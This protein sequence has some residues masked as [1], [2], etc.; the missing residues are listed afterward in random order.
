VGSDGVRL[1][2]AFPDGVLRHVC[3]ECN[4]L[5][6]R[7]NAI[8]G[9]L[10]REM[11][12]LLRIYPRLESA[13]VNRI[14]D[15]ITVAMPL[16]RCAFLDDDRLCRIHKDHGTSLKPGVC[17]VFPFNLLRT[18][19]PVVTVAPVFGLCPLRLQLPPRPGDVEGTHARVEEALHDSGLLEA[20][21]LRAR[22]PALLARPGDD[23]A[24]VLG[25]EAAFRDACGAALSDVAFATL[26]RRHAA[27]PW[28]LADTVARATLLL[29]WDT[30]PEGPAD[31]ID[32]LLLA[33]APSLRLD[34]LFLPP[35]AMLAALA[36]GERAARRLLPLASARP[37]LQG[38]HHLLSM[39][40]PALRLL[41]LGE[42]RFPFPLPELMPRFRDPELALSVLLAFRGLKTDGALPALEAAVPA[43]LGVSDRSLLF[44]QLGRSLEQ[45]A[46]RAT[47]TGRAGP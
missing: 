6:C 21:Y 16:G 4:A 29:G 10:G 22:A 11:R 45:A 41:A 47:G 13:V 15:V 12:A 2:F 20:E 35:D 33:L 25:R 26:L 30:P 28:R 5:C 43:A 14:G 31:E 44:S 39:L 19:G 46:M 1:F 9:S 34:M 27:A 32:D 24:S 36:L 3:A 40:G 42:E 8:D 37:T 23:A 17:V 7:G 38:T 18:L